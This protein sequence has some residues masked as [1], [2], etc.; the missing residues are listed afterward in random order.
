MKKLLL[1]TALAI[2]GAGTAHAL[3]VD[4]S[5][6]ATGSGAYLNNLNAGAT[7]QTATRL[8]FGSV[9]SGAGNGFGTV[10]TILITVTSGSFGAYLG[11]LE[12]I[13]DVQ[14]AS[15]A[16]PTS[17]SP[18]TS[19]FISFG[20]GALTLDFSTAVVARSANGTGLNITG[21]GTFASG[22]DRSS[23]T[24][25]LTTTSAGGQVAATTFTFTTSAQTVSMPGP[26]SLSVLG[27]ALVGLGLLRHRRRKH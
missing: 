11:T 13:S 12:S 23:G 7:A 19:P 17:A 21:A 3:P 26:N 5:F 10:G 22:A 6:A 20:A 27:A 2:L 16:D 25:A 8:D 1:G 9:F 15:A 18:N 4:G 14:F 24:F